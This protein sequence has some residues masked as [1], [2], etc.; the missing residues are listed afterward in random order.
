MDNQFYTTLHN[1]CN[2]ISMLGLKLISGGIDSTVLAHQ[3]ELSLWECVIIFSFRMDNPCSHL[4]KY[5]DG[6]VLLWFT[7][8]RDVYGREPLIK[9]VYNLQIFMFILLALSW[10]TYVYIR[11]CNNLGTYADQYIC[12][13]ARVCARFGK[14]PKYVWR[15]YWIYCRRFLDCKMR[16]IVYLY[17]GILIDVSI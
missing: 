14:F 13:T 6:C 2:Y 12:V 10:Y 1:G 8:Y 4:E 17:I 15:M 3:I 5:Q 11:K 9:L 7:V 16:S